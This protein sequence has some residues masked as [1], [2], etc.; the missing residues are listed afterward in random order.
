MGKA[1]KALLIV[2][3]LGVLLTWGMTAFAQEGSDKPGQSDKPGK[4]GP[5]GH[6]GMRGHRG[7]PDP[8]MAHPKIGEEMK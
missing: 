8:T 5:K 4:M 2:A 1:F 6:K 7:P 3:M